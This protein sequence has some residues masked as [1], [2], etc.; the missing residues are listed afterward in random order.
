MYSEFCFWLRSSILPLNSEGVLHQVN[1]YSLLRCRKVLQVY[2]FSSVSYEGISFCRVFEPSGN[3]GILKSF[4]QGYL[5]IIIGSISWSSKYV[6]SLWSHIASHT[7]YY[8][9]CLWCTQGHIFLFLSMSVNP[10]RLQ[11][12]TSTGCAFSVDCTFFSIWIDI[13]HKLK[14][15]LEAYLGPYPTV[16]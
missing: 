1:V 15:T 6:E 16:S 2:N 3:T 8:I 10:S 14:F 11:G 4:T 9:L 5:V 13:F 12:R 7:H